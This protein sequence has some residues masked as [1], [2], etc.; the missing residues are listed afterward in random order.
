MILPL[1]KL[2][3]TEN[4]PE[5]DVLFRYFSIMTEIGG[6]KKTKKSNRL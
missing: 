6:H 3:K 1:L 4:E 5:T 2:F